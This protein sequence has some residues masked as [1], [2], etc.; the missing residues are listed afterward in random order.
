M[1]TYTVSRKTDPGRSRLIRNG[2]DL[3]LYDG[4]GKGSEESD[5]SKA[6]GGSRT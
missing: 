2:C 6:D 3:L 4:S 1:L 5:K